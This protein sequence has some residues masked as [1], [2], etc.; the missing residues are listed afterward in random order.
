[1]VPLAEY[2][3]EP[4]GEAQTLLDSP[5]LQKIFDDLE[6]EAF[7]GIIAAKQA[8]DETRRLLSME[9]QAIRSVRRQLAERA[10]GKAK[11]RRTGSSA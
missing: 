6:A 1:M 11:P 5:L 10:A 8:D 2:E 9:V 4:S 3:I 7:E